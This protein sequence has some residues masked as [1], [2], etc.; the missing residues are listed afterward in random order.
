MITIAH[1]V[2]PPSNGCPKVHKFHLLAA[3]VF[4]FQL[5]ADAAALAAIQAGDVFG[6]TLLF[7][8]CVIGA[9]GGAYCAV[10]CFPPR[11]S[12][13]CQ[14][15]SANLRMMVRRLCA[16]FGFSMIGSATITPLLMQVLSIDTSRAMVVGCAS[17]VAFA[18]VATIHFVA[19]FIER[20]NSKKV[21]YITNNGPAQQQLGD[22]NKQ[23]Q[24]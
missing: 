15:D 9:S 3:F 10:F 17:I 16:K 4:V 13:T 24:P 22:H 14:S 18:I 8:L 5:P 11:E 21:V 20:V 7:L 1:H 6:D 2:L 23:S 12:P 19:G